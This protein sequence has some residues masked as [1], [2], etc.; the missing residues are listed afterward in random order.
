MFA[1]RK[2]PA[3]TKSISQ[4]KEIT[5]EATTTQKGKKQILETPTTPRINESEANRSRHRKKPSTT[6]QVNKMTTYN[7]AG[8]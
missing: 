7:Q 8:R 3:A 2:K 1:T 6:T 4:S 5:T